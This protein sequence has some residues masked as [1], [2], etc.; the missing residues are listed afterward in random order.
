MFPHQQYRI[1]MTLRFLHQWTQLDNL[2]IAGGPETI[3]TTFEL[4]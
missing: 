4:K 1:G 2:V 3:V